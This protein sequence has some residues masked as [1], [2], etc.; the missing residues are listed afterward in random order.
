MSDV[1]RSTRKNKGVRRAYT[2][3]PEPPKNKRKRT[4]KK[5][6]MMDIKQ[7]TLEYYRERAAILP[8]IGDPPTLIESHIYTNEELE[9][10]LVFTPTKRKFVDEDE[11][12]YHKIENQKEEKN[13]GSAAID[14]SKLPFK[15]RFKY[16][17]NSVEMVTTPNN[18]G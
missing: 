8:E 17:S 15:K 10:M 13:S 14:I 2:P 18:L 4:C 6:N 12:T 1:R 16:L 11:F 3:P 5:K 9:A 7:R